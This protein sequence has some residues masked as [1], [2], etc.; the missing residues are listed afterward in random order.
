M[1][2]IV[3]L[4]REPTVA[5]SVLTLSLVIAGGLALGNVRVRG[6]SLGIGGVLFAGLLL[7]HLGLA[8]DPHTLEFVREFGLILFVYATGLQLGGGFFS[9]LR[10]QG[11]ALNLL[12]VGIVVGGTALALGLAPL[13]QVPLP[14]LVGLLSGAVT[15]TPGMGAAQHA[16]AEGGAGAEATQLVGLGYAVAYPFGILGTITAL[17]ILKRLF[18]FDPVKEGAEVER[19]QSLGSKPLSLCNL[20]VTN[21]NLV[22]HTVAQV[23]D[24][25]GGG[26]AVSRLV[27]GDRQL[28][29]TGDVEIAAG[30]VLHVVGTDERIERL[31]LIAGRISERDLPAMP[32]VMTV[33]RVVVTKGQHVDRSLEDL[34]LAGRYGVV[35]T[36]VIR[37]GVE[38]SP[39]RSMKLQFGDRLNVVGSESAIERVAHELGDEV[40]ELDRAQFV[41]IFLGI[42]LGVLLGSLPVAFP[43]VPAPVK[44]GLAGGPLLVAL[45]MGRIGKVG[46]FVS[47][48]PNAAKKA[49]AELGIAL[50]LACVGVSAGARVGQVLMTADGL[51]WLGLGALIT[52]VP[53]MIVGIIGRSLRKLDASSLYGLLAGSMT[54]PPALAYA[55]QLVGNDTPSIAYATVYPLTMLLRVVLAQAVVMFGLG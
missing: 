30:D 37:A 15:N 41:P 34:D 29:A 50:F 7:G 5:H 43:G 46:P 52:F 13:F 24:L 40:K 44:L 28:L 17:L 36:R 20:E 25:A 33:R 31:R 49:L 9:S 26:I 4:F 45:M 19:L 18:R 38:F 1:D 48:V 6:I 22:G 8:L 55:G 14:T 10:R 54:D 47:Y 32:S 53:I 2:W 42:A 51:T 3:A 11:L 16:L 39:T 35:V 27:R 12:A 23:I 21:T